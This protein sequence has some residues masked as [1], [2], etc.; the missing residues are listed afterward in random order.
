MKRTTLAVTIAGL[1]LMIGVLAL[2]APGMNRH[3]PGQRGGPGHERGADGPQRMMQH[4]VHQLMHDPEAAGDLGITEEQRDQI[5]QLRFDTQ[6]QSIELRARVE[7]A[8][9]ELRHLMQQDQPQE[10]AVMQAI[11]NVGEARI[12][13]EKVNVAGMLKTRAM[14]GTETWRQLHQRAAARFRRHM[15]RSENRDRPQHQRPNDAH[16]RGPH[17]ERDAQGRG[18]RGDD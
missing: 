6:K 1:T 2:A 5:R 18:P 7:L 9:L 10:P 3:Q 12:A 15:Q 17:G 11:E 8:E 14:L 4:I 13:M 16:R